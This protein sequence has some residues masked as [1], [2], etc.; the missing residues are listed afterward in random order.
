MYTITN[1]NV[2][3]KTQSY[4]LIF[5]HGTFQYKQFSNQLIKSFDSLQ[6]EKASCKKSRK[7]QL[8]VH[9]K[10]RPI[11]CIIIKGANQGKFFI[12]PLQIYDI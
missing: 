8:P 4:N 11:V 1:A 5:K 9:L 6:A 7:K 12:G 2:R 3:F 10:E